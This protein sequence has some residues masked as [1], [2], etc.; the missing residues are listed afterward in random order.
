MQLNPREIQVGVKNLRTISKNRVLVQCV[1]KVDK[2]K[3]LDAI[4]K[5]SDLLQV[6]SKKRRNPNF[7]LKYIPNEIDDQEILQIFKEQNPEIGSEKLWEE[8][9][10]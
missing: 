7:P 8:T 1:S 5:K 9:K 4:N 10:I 6:S 3:F 2:E